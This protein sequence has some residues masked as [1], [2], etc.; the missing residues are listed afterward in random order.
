MGPF[1]LVGMIFLFL[2][3]VAEASTGNRLVRFRSA[4]EQRYVFLGVVAIWV[5]YGVVR[6]IVELA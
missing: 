4:R 5:V 3:F 2:A 1:A 6:A